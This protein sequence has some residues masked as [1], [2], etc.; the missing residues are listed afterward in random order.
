MALETDETGRKYLK[1]DFDHVEAKKIKD[2]VCP[3]CGGD[4]VQTAF[5]YGCANYK[6]DDPESCRFSIGKMGE[7]N[8]K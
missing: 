8:V 6:K 5:G 1:F 3:L 7:K 2:V 4:I